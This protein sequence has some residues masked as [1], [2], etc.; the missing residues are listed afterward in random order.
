M[1]DKQTA[2]VIHSFTQHVLIKHP[3]GLGYSREIARNMT[4]SWEV[5]VKVR[6]D[7]FKK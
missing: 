2:K 5:G 4:V 1:K 6:E 3:P 7:L